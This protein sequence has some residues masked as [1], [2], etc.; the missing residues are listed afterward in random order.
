[1]PSNVRAITY[2]ELTGGAFMVA[3][4]SALHFVFDWAG[5]W[6]PLAIVAAVNESIWE[7]LKLVFWPGVLWAFLAPTPAGLD[8]SDHLV[9]KAVTLPVTAGLIVA[10]F[11]SYTAILGR[12]LLPLDIGT[13]VLSIFAGQV[14][15][16]WLLSRYRRWL[17][18]LRRPALSILGLQLAA[19]SLFTYHPPDHWLFIEASSQTRGMPMP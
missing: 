18:A 19:Y 9:V 3:L 5:G 14:L 8:R 15:S 4:G 13:F 12:N 7:H 6:W 16:I 2:S 17:R 10:I 1:M 11:T